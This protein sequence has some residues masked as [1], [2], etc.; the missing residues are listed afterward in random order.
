MSSTTARV[1]MRDLLGDGD[2]LERLG[3]SEWI[4]R[5]RAPVGQLRLGSQAAT[6]DLIRCSPLQHALTSPVVSLIEAL[7]QRLQIPMAIDG[8][9]QHLAL[10]APVEALH[11]T[12][13]LRRVGLGLAVLQLQLAAGV[14]ESI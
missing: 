13:R 10:H 1:W 2:D 12:I 14:L 8:D 4:G 5:L 7:E 3:Q 6:H 9:A 11:E